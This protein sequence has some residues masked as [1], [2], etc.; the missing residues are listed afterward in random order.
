[1]SDAGIYNLAP[2]PYGGTVTIHGGYVEADG[3]E[4]YAAG[5]ALPTT[6]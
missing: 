1:M 4:K 6:L 3:G 2:N 5:V